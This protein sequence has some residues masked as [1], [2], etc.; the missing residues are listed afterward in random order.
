MAKKKGAGTVEQLGEAGDDHSDF[1]D[2]IQAAA[3]KQMQTQY[4]GLDMLTHEETL[5]RCGGIAM[6]GLCLRYLLH[7]EAFPL[8]RTLTLS[9]L[10]RSN[11]TSLAF[12][13][14]RWALTYRGLGW[15]NDVER[16]DSP[17]MRESML[18]YNKEHLKYVNILPCSVQ[19]HW[20]SGVTNQFNSVL[21]E[22]VT[23]GGKFRVIGCSIV[24]SVAA[25]SP[26]AEA[27][28]FISKHA[29]AG[30]RAHPTVALY[31]SKWLTD[32]VH[33]V[34]A[35]PFILLLIQ[36]SAEVQVEGTTSMTRKQKGGMEVAFAK[37]TA[38]EMTRV[39][40]MKETSKGG[41][42]LIKIECSKNALGPTKRKIEVPVRWFWEP[43]PDQPGKS[44]QR[45]FW[46]WPHATI[47]TLLSYEAMPGMK[48]TWNQIK[49]V[50]DLHVASGARVW[51]R[52]L[53]IP[54]ESPVKLSTAGE[55]LE[56][57][58]MELLPA[59]YDILHV[60]RRAV[61]KPGG[62]VLDVW[63]GKKLAQEIPDAPPYPRLNLEDQG[64]A[65]E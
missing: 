50:C 36:H 12:E 30:R 19:E 33:Y 58:H 22:S 21:Q 5:Q 35:G 18:G 46:D 45:Y 41:G 39:Q 17:G 10:F 55:I 1:R 53:G 9:G 52:A 44:R 14:M 59:L 62:D 29:G 27:V 24:D 43:N 54:K 57:E 48:S 49:E 38:F 23:H 34:S 51:S 60:E 31:N 56:Y 32:I 37:T 47:K 16:K 65:D 7:N 11:K 61:M 63:N 28:E 13:M 3:Q 8:G 15:Y 4:K 64:D 42:A 40:D 25:A 2:S 20:Q 6:P 26:A